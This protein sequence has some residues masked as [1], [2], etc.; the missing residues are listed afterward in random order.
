MEKTTKEIEQR[1]KKL[2]ED[3]HY[4]NYCY[5]V[6][7]SPVISDAEYDRL[8]REL[9]EL[10]DKYPHLITPDSPTQ[11]VGAAPLEKF[12][13]VRHALPMLSLENAFDEAEAREFEQR[14]KRFLRMDGLIDYVA[15]PKMDGL[16]IE[17]VYEDGLLSTAST[18]GDGVTGED[19]TQNVRT[20]KSIPLRL[21]R[22]ESIPRRLEAR[23]EV[24]L[25][26]KAFKEINQ[27]RI[28]D[29]EPPF[30]NP[31]NAAAGSLRQLDPRVTARRPLD[32]FAY[33]VGVVEGRSFTSQWEILTVL[34]RLGIKV[35]PLIRRC[36]GIEGCIDY[37]QELEGRRRNLAYEIDGMV[38]KVD[39]F[40][41]Q[42]RLGVKTRSPRWAVAYKFPANQA[43][44]RIL[45]IQVQVGRTGTL[46]PVAIMEPVN[47]GGA[48]VSRATLHNQDE[49]ARK[50]IR[51][52]DTVL[53]Q[54]A[55]E[56]I[57]EV[58]KSIPEKRTG[59]EK[60][61]VMPEICPV[62]GARVVQ[63]PYEVAVRCPNTSCPAQVKESIAH[64]ASKSGMDIEGLGEKIVAQL[65]DSGVIKDAAD[66]Y[67]LTREQILALER[68][69]ARSTENILVAIDKSKQTSLL[70]FLYALGI[71][72]VGEKTAQILAEKFG[73]L[74]ALATAAME[75]LMEID[76]IGPQV[77]ASVTT[78]FAEK[79][80]QDVIHRLLAAGVSPAP[81][82]PIGPR[83]LAGQSF[84]FTGGL[85]S[86]SRD[87]AKNKVKEL[88]GIVSSS[89]SRK[90]NYVV[91][92]KDPGS[93][94]AR[95]RELGVTILT[96]E[97]FKRLIGA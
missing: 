65:V 95:A 73:S 26:L 16:A 85:E 66:L 81:P 10:E 12:G 43:S 19:V 44:T 23:G 38:I 17:I 1:I 89:A 40:S 41:L 54:R 27:Q 74:A 60:K 53:I 77:A 49:I 24:F 13:T 93:K 83:P 32:F 20:I 58:V 48:E 61:F 30:A 72:Y 55:G 18:R 4:H 59:K 39:S 96:E 92:G 47:I 35:N 7:D 5:Y 33:G 11:R 42:D 68:F 3:I 64:F 76:E 67:Y 71:R 25:S 94:L 80:N 51:I 78:F 2:R 91:A 37:F 29:G 50:D 97:E 82:V 15:E 86:F 28:R 52:G 75:Q 9:I 34:P 14:I 88:G 8:M 79:K 69:A 87:E 45:D 22:G 46:T 63:L 57:P 21:Q 70:R 56:V 36:K 6:L 90:T 62:C 84:V 31:R